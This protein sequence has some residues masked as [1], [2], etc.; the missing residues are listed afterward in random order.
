MISR[1]SEANYQETLRK[2][3][4]WL[5][6][7]SARGVAI[8]EEVNGF[9][10]RYERQDVDTVFLQRFFTVDDIEALPRG[11]MRL[12]RTVVRRIGHKLRGLAGEPGGY[13]DLLRALGFHLDEEGAGRV[14]LVEDEIADKLVVTYYPAPGSTNEATQQSML[15]GPREREELR[16]EA[17][18]RR[19]AESQVRTPR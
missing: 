14:Q 9:V 5:D 11:D 15:L 8:Q 13:Q 3:G 10:V 16:V 1:L 7:A 2:I 18:A 19:R 12:R 17:H 6:G 4:A